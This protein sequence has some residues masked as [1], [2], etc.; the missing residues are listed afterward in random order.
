MINEF[1]NE[2]ELIKDVKKDN[3]F[4]IDDINSEYLQNKEVKKTIYNRGI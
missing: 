3:P 2:E 4:F 1:L